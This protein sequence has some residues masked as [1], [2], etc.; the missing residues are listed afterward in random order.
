MW[1]QKGEW[2]YILNRKIKYYTKEAFR[3]INLVAIALFIIVLVTFI[4]YQLVCEVTIDGEKVGYI[5]DKEQFEKSIQDYINAE[6]D[7]KQYTTIEKMP[8]YNVTL[9]NRQ[10]Q[11]NEEVILAKI[12]ENSETTY[13]LYAVTIDGKEKA[14]LTNLN[15]AEKLIKELSDKYEKKLNIKIGIVEKITT[16]NKT[17]VITVK[18]AKSD[19]TKELK[20]KVDKLNTQ[21]TT[22]TTTTAKVSLNGVKLSVTPVSGIITSRFGSR[23]SIRTSGH[24]GLDIGAP[25]GTTIKAAASGTVTYSGY[26][27]GYGN[28]VIISHGEGIE[29]YYGHCSKLSV[30]KGDVVSAGDK[31]GEVG[32][33]GN[34]TGNHLHFEVVKNGVKLNPQ[35]YLYVNK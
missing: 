28:L 16:D 8:E 12:K 34:S 31:I 33:T 26:C 5:A 18:T 1:N 23:E 27:G 4:K 19:I 2:I 10:E 6:E 24:K 13:K 21:K 9:V 20:S 15:E 14:I 30:S 29:T 35:N 3:L 11:T 7:N 22:Y 32:S 17:D 25:K